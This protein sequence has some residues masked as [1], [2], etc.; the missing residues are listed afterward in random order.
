MGFPS[1]KDAA[2][3]DEKLLLQG[4][5]DKG[6]TVSPGGFGK[7]VKGAAGPD[8]PKLV[9]DPVIDEVPFAP[10]LI[11]EGSRVVVEG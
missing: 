11:D 5:L 6:I 9:F 4:P 1:G 7:E 3:Y 10:E 2:R 8:H